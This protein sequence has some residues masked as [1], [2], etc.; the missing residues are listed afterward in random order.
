MSDHER[1]EAAAFRQLE[2]L[3][4]SLGEEL[5]GF[6]RRA[7]QAEARARSLDATVS[8]GADQASLERVR[9]LEAENAELKERLGHV[10]T[11]TRQLLS[12]VKFLRQQ[13][14]QGFP[15]HAAQGDR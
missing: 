5:A 15:T 13:K 7:H 6:R 12:R 3:V 11:R 10:T 1:P 14:Q 2:Q 8:T 9:Q 4:R